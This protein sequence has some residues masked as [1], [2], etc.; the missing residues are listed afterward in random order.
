MNIEAIHQ[1]AHVV[2]TSTC[3]RYFNR[4]VISY[5]EFDYL[6]N[7]VGADNPYK[8]TGEDYIEMDYHDE[9][10]PLIEQARSKET[11]NNR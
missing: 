6:T 4:V 2:S 7:L 8:N 5:D 10:I 3:G 9:F 1:N 11:Q